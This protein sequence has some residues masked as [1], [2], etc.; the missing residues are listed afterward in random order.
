MAFVLHTSHAT[1]YLSYIANVWG[2]NHR[3]KSVPWSSPSSESREHNP[4]EK[5]L[6]LG[7]LCALRFLRKRR[8][9]EMAR[10]REEA[11]GG[12]KELLHGLEEMSL[13]VSLIS[14][15]RVTQK[16][17]ESLSKFQ[18]KTITWF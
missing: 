10:R 12:I 3:V 1:S 17:A 4:E 8:E 16:S 7:G 6:L 15:P 5:K 13:Q 11:G 9:R 14:C 2:A 18:A